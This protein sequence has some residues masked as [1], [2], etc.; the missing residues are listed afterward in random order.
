[1]REPARPGADTEPG[2]TRTVIGD[3]EELGLPRL[4]INACFCCR[5]AGDN[6]DRLCRRDIAHGRDQGVLIFHGMTGEVSGSGRSSDP[7][8]GKGGTIA[9][10]FLNALEPTG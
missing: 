10:D 6:V 2:P 3:R 1:M 5:L 7:V 8:R 4:R 9:P